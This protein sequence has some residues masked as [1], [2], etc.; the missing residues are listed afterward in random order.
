MKIRSTPDFQYFSNLEYSRFCNSAW[1]NENLEYSRFRILL[2]K[3]SNLEYSRFQKWSEHIHVKNDIMKKHFP[4]NEKIHQMETRNE[5]LFK[6]KT[7][8]TQQYLL[9]NQGF[10]MHFFCSILL[11]VIVSSEF[12]Y[13]LIPCKH[14][15]TVNKP[16]LS[17]YL[18]AADPLG[19]LK[20]HI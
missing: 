15:I 19:H 5:K 17:L 3:I 1:K 8:H 20:G 11:N 12:L 2:S 7:A 10:G 18:M 14:H 6:I 4:K 16:S 9:N 13:L